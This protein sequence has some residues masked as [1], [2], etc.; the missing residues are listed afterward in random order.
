MPKVVFSSDSKEDLKNIV[1]FTKRKWGNEKA[2]DYVA[3]LRKLAQSLAETPGVG[4]KRDDLD[5][6]LLSF[7]YVSHFLFYIVD[8]QGITIARVLHKNQEPSIHF[9]SPGNA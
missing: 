3:G 1:R 9:S 8:P 2:V 4:K 5:S 6:E 7:P